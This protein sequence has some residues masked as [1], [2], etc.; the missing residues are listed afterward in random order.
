MR[1]QGKSTGG[2]INSR[3]VSC[4]VFG[5]GLTRYMSGGDMLLGAGMSGTGEADRHV[6]RWEV[7]DMSAAQS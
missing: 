2:V 5:G 1:L 3:A 4:G 7:T 6:R